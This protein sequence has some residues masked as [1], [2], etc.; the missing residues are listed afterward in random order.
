MEIKKERKFAN[1]YVCSLELNDGMKIEA[2]NT[3]LPMN[4][5]L[6]GYNNKK[7]NK[8]NE[9]DFGS[10]NDKHMIGIS[11]QT[12]C[13]VQCKFC[14]VNKITEKYGW[15]NL[16]V[17]EMIEQIDTILDKTKR[18]YGYDIFKNKPKLL[19]VLFT[20][21]GEPSFNVRNISET[22]R[23]LKRRFEGFNL[24]VQISTI[25]LHNLTYSLINE[26]ILL[27]KE[28]DENFIELQFSVH[29]T[30]N[31]FRKWLQTDR[32]LDNEEINRL[33][34]KFYYSRKHDWKTTLNFSLAE[35]TPF[36]LQTL[37][38]Q[39]NKDCNFI[40]LSPINETNS[41]KENNLH[42]LF[43]NENNI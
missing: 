19:R 26:L 28:Y 32:I 21:M 1:G 14:E 39:F 29:S 3:F 20:R 38:K 31:S 17:G 35:E 13:P 4:T 12:G 15:R 37:E 10:W 41:S 5:E 40:K 25:G 23:F 30:S 34:E 8:V 6:R 36:D 7:D 2:T 43:K 24:R 18:D 16:T 11:T 33:S 42:S 27:E 9:N 22:I